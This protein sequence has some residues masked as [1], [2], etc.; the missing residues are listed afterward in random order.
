VRV[1][2]KSKVV[3]HFDQ[4]KALIASA[5]LAD[6]GAVHT[7]AINALTVFDVV[8]VHPL[9]APDARASDWLR[10]RRGVFGPRNFP[11]QLFFRLLPRACEISF[12]SCA[13]LIRKISHHWEESRKDIAPD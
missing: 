2:F 7:V 6:N 13:S 4:H 12:C 9:F 1:E 3:V 11:T 10:C 5:S 8:H